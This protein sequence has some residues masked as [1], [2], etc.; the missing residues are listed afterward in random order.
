MTSTIA[1]P[2]ADADTEEDDFPFRS[3]IS[4]QPAPMTVSKNSSNPTKAS[5]DILISNDGLDDVPCQSLTV[6]FTVADDDWGLDAENILTPVWRKVSWP[7]PELPPG[8]VE[9][10]SDQRSGV[11]TFRPENNVAEPNDTL[12][13]H[14]DNIHVSAVKG[15]TNIVIYV[16]TPEGKPTY[17]PAVHSLGKFPHGFQL[18]NF[19]AD[20][21]IV[22]SGQSTT[23]NWT[24]DGDDDVSYRFFVNGTEKELKN[25]TIQ[26]PYDTGPLH[27]TTIFKISAIHQVGNDMIP[28]S[29]STVVHV[30][31]GDLT[32]STIRSK[33]IIA[34]KVK[35]RKI[36]ARQAVIHLRPPALVETMADSWQMTMAQWRHD[37]KVQEIRIENQPC[38]GFLTGEFRVTLPG[39]F[40]TTGSI[41]LDLV[42]RIYRTDLPIMTTNMQFNKEAGY[43]KQHFNLFFPCDEKWWLIVGRPATAGTLPAETLLQLNLYWIKLGAD[44]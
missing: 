44:S 39:R 16:E 25:G 27:S 13:L 37:A 4:T 19:R 35:T 1:P 12:R 7:E 10:T 36:T 38:D 22:E 30:H 40:R 31:G 23:L 29:D 34:S 26:P 32:A 33:Q 2:T 21:P 41:R 24:V 6:E 17:K 8:W 42:H 11:F 43:A 28:F 15:I 5:L 3:S 18:T 9:D 14:L 20:D